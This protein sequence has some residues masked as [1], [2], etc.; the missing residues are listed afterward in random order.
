M[1]LSHYPE[2][3]SSSPSSNYWYE[4]PYKLALRWPYISMLRYRHD[5]NLWPLIHEADNLLLNH[6]G[7]SPQIQVTPGKTYHLRSVRSACVCEVLWKARNLDTKSVASCAALT[8]SCLGMTSNE[9]ANSAIASCS[10]ELC[11][12]YFIQIIQCI[13]FVQIC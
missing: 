10:L 9:C 3:E 4:L 11:R 1:P 12:K 5:L 2:M 6:Q 13:I 8:A 7:G